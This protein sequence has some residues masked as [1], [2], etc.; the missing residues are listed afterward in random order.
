M[1][2]DTTQPGDQHARLHLR[3]QPQHAAADDPEALADP[4]RLLVPQGGLGRATTTSRSG[5]ELL[6]VALR[7]VLHSRRCTATSTSTTRS[8]ATT[9]RTPTSTRSPTRSPARP[10]TNEADDNWT[11]V[12][13]YVQDDWKPNAAPD[14]EPGPALRDADRPLLEQLRHVGTARPRGRR[15]QRPAQARHEQLRAARRLRLRREGRREARGARRLRAATTTRSSRTSRSTRRGAT[16]RRR[17][18]SSPLSPAPFTPQLSTRR[19]ATRSA[20]RFIDPTFAGQLM[21]L[22]APDLKQP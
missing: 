3:R 6:Q 8:R 7:R 20:T 19:T 22:T 21:R 13:G 5:G 1:A 4:R 2:E 11:Y 17:S 9:A 10:A 15:L 16:R 12:A 14:A 18:T